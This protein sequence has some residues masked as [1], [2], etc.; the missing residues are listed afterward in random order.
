MGATAT[1]FWFG[2]GSGLQLSI[3]EDG[4]NCTPTGHPTAT[5]TYDTRKQAGQAI[6][7]FRAAAPRSR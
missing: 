3:G 6:G 5:G 7:A 2:P 4:R 1:Y